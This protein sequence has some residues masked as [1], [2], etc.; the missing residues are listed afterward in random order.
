MNNNQP[1][2]GVSQG[3]PTDSPLVAKRKDELL[4]YCQSFYR[5]SWD[6]RSQGFHAKWDRFDRNYE[7]IYDPQ[8]AASKEPWQSTM[9]VD[10][11]IQ[12]VEI[13]VSNIFKT[14]MA[15]SPPIQTEPGPDG[16]ELQ[17]R[18]IQDV[19]EYEL[20]KSVFK[21]NFY[22]ALKESVRYGSGFMKL[23]WERV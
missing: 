22:D 2:V 15:P 10:I 8:K 12:N 21:V 4:M 20:E 3:K 17:A 16:D 5:R 7:S 14:M 1:V 23:Y 13:I 19:V 18:L 11:T 6:W 9:F